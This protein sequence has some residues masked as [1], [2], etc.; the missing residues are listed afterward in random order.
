MH[1]KHDH[2]IPTPT[3]TTITERIPPIHPM[4]PQAPSRN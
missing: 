4:K 2:P 1:Q 3:I